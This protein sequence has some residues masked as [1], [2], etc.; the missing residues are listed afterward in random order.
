MGQIEE[1]EPKKPHDLEHAANI[2]EAESRA[3]D[4]VF[5]RHAYLMVKN[6]GYTWEQALTAVALALGDARNALIKDYQRH[7][8]QCVQPPIIVQGKK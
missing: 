7:M 2:A 8:E 5:F 3:K 1:Y 4:D 6:L